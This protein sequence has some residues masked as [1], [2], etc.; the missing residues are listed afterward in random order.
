[1]REVPLTEASVGDKIRL[2]IEGREYIGILMPHHRFSGDDTITLKLEN[3]YN[4]GL[5]V[6]EGTIVK[7]LESDVDR[8]ESTLDIPEVEEDKPN[9]SI[10]G[11]GGTIASYVE[12]G[13]GAVHPAETAAEILYSNPEIAVRCDPKVDIILSKLSEDITP[14]D[15]VTIADAVLEELNSGAE[16]VVVAHGTDTMG[17]TAA[18]LSFL[19]DQVPK[20]VVLVG[21]QRSSDRPSSD[22]HLN[23]LAAI[24]VAKSNT[25]GVYVVMH[26]TID[27]KRCAVHHGTKV[28]KMHTSR[29]DAFKSI[30]REQAGWVEPLDNGLD[31]KG[32]PEKEEKVATRMGSIE[33]EVA[34]VYVTPALTEEDLQYAGKKKGIVLVGTGLGHMRSELISTLKEI[35]TDGTPVV[36]T[37]QCLYGT[38]NCYVYTN[39]RKLLE[40]GVIPCGD[41]LPETALVKL[42]WALTI[43]GQDVKETMITDAAGEI[44]NRRME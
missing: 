21:S 3:G 18:A 33:P 41:M 7:L 17:Y 11:T 14:K 9:I 10:I 30:N 2:E 1:M 42:M 25:R 32:L 20:P 38:V 6:A 28:R 22:A 26:E 19:L 40:A 4:I 24:D 31:L 23:L 5:K 35:I 12:Y 27:D 16:G 37:S 34:L 13:T 43:I 8:V 39:G 44:S 36:M 15:W 29:R